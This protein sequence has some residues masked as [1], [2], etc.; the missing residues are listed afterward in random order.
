MTLNEQL[1]AADA[2]EPKEKRGRGR[3]RTIFARWQL[4]DTFLPKM[5][6]KDF[7]ELTR[8]DAF[9]RRV[10]FAC[11]EF[12]RKMKRQLAIVGDQSFIIEPAK[13]KAQPFRRTPSA[14]FNIMMSKRR[15]Q[16]VLNPRSYLVSSSLSYAFLKIK[17]MPRYDA[18]GKP[19]FKSYYITAVNNMLL[20]MMPLLAMEAAQDMPTTWEP[21]KE[22]RQKQ[23]EAEQ[24][25]PY[26]LSESNVY[27]GILDS[28]SSE[29][30]KEIEGIER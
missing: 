12:D 8:D 4:A 3:P 11:Q 27:F 17:S 9:M 2:R 10:E 6:D 21:S 14:D 15:G 20:D 13:E 25:D 22:E 5:S 1:D 7:R 28:V 16:P 26:D 29:T 30:A 23:K 18:A 19:H 24:G